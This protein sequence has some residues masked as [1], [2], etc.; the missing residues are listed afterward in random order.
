M[1]RTTILK[2]K[3][4]HIYT[5]LHDHV[6]ESLLQREG[7]SAFVQQFDSGCLKVFSCGEVLQ[8]VV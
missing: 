2:G 3:E 5:D 8:Q 1:M 6:A 4:V 7:L